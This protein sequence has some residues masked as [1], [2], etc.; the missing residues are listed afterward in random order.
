[1]PGK[2]ILQ[3]TQGPLEGRVFTFDTHDTF[4]FGRAP[5]CHACLSEADPTAS[6]HHFLLEINP[7]EARIRD[8]GS[9]NGTYVNGVKYGGRSPIESPEDA[10]AREFPEVDLSDGDRIQVGDS[11]FLVRVES[12][13]VCA[14][15]GE[16]IEDSARADCSY[17]DGRYTCPQCLDMEGRGIS[18]SDSQASRCRRC[19]TSLVAETDARAGTELLCRS[20]RDEVESNP[21][22]DLMKALAAKFQRSGKLGKTDIPGYEI[23]GKIGP[24]G[25]GAVY[26]AR[27]KG[28]G[29]TVAIKVMLS[30]VRVYDDAREVFKREIDVTMRLAHENIVALYEHG[31]ADNLFYFV[32]EYCAGGSVE[33]LVKERGG[34]LAL[35]EA[36]PIILQALDGL[37]YAHE[38]GFVHRDLSPKNILLTA[39]EGGTAKISDLGLAKNFQQAGFSGMTVTGVALGNPNLMP[40]EQLLNFKHVKPVSD[41]WGITA[42]LY[43]MLTGGIPYHVE[44]GLTPVDAVFE[45]KVIPI[46]DRL[47]KFP[48]DLAEVIDKG[49]AVHVQDRYQTAAELREALQR[50][51]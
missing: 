8:L 16:A 42:T 15:C 7:P 39:R 17:E 45:G 34:R 23:I 33:S 48:R 21:I 51:L 29:T 22:Q 3:V 28:D 35:E 43:N 14:S 50:F 9:L 5:G 31:S 38:Q 47:P 26:R 4:V 19:G 36:C 49:L 20:C 24:G 12:L 1:M 30:K 6:R 32:M 46:R 18:L 40:R 37:C 41:V 10:A 27:R 44:G 11:V 2:V 13:A 25:M